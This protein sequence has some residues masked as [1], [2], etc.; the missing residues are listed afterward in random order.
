MSDLTVSGG[1]AESVVSLGAYNTLTTSRQLL[2]GSG[3]RRNT[4]PD[5]QCNSS[6]MGNLVHL[7][8]A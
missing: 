4:R 8:D 5:R 3:K 1:G 6:D 2:E 7:T